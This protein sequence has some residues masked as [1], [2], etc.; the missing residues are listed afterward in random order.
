MFTS[1]DVATTVQNMLDPPLRPVDRLLSPVRGFLQHRLAGAA[2]LML[3]TVVAV[4]L[5]NSPWEHAYHHFLHQH[6]E[7]DA[8]LLGLD[9]TIHHWINDGMMSVF[10]F[11][12]GLEIKRELLVGELS[13]VRKATLPAIAAVGG[14]LV[15][16]GFFLVL[17]AGTATQHGWGIPM[18]TDI[19]FA[20]G[21]LALLGDRVPVGAKVFLTALAIVDDIGAVLVIALFYTTEINFTALSAGFAFLLVGIMLNKLDVRGSFAYLL[22][23]MC[24]WVAFLKSGIHATIAA[25]LMALV[26]PATTRINGRDLVN[27]IE[28]IT[29]KLRAIGLPEDTKM[30][31]ADQEHA[32][33]AMAE[34]IE[35]AQAPLQRIEHDLH[36]P[37][38]FFVLPVFALA[39]AGVTLGGDFTHDLMSPLALGIVI[40][41]FFG[42]QVGITLATW[43][44]VTLRLADLPSGVTWKQIHGVNI[45]A[46]VGFTMSLFVSSLAFTDLHHIAQA[47]IGILTASI[48]S[49]LVGYYFLHT[50]ENIRRSRLPSAGVDYAPP[51]AS[52]GSIEA[53]PPV[54]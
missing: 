12:V 1:M 51:G 19:A 27:R 29:S 22:V 40:G 46:G 42:K 48:L 5:A 7:V 26:I 18:A 44:A 43:L 41:L 17:N 49:G 15:P 8:G 34:T 30:N 39:N 32:I 14:M 10:F 53:P 23:G 4:V 52:D 20:L 38:T 36:G 11:L 13:S 16:A 47:K 45:L 35:H 21:V 6:I 28:I 3:A 50:L 37:V 31:S 9:Y 2:L 24:V 54:L 25:I 33:I